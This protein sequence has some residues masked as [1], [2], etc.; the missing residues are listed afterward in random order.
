MLYVTDPT[1]P[2]HPLKCSNPKPDPIPRELFSILSEPEI[3]Q[4]YPK[5]EI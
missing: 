5:P 3:F 2:P 1:L 4:T